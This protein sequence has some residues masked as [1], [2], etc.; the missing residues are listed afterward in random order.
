MRTPAVVLN[1]DTT[2]PLLLGTGAPGVPMTLTDPRPLTSMPCAAFEVNSVWVPAVLL[3]V[4]E[5]PGTIFV[6]DGGAAPMTTM[7]RVM[8]LNAQPGAE[9][10]PDAM[11]P[12]PVESLP[13]IGST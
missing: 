9:V 5:P 12:V 4:A 1:E 8:V 11:L 6:P 2:V 3:I 7:A 10:A 13:L